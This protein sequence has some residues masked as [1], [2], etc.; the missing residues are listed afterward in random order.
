MARNL[1]GSVLV[2]YPSGTSPE[3]VC[4]LACC[5]E[6]AVASRSCLGSQSWLLLRLVIR[7]RRVEKP[8]HRH[9]RDTTTCRLRKYFA[10]AFV[11]ECRYSVCHLVRLRWWDQ[12]LVCEA[13]S[14]AASS[15]LSASR[16]PLRLRSP[17]RPVRS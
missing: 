6:F 15:S 1:I 12:W 17:F 5:A 9:C 14:G 2:Q 8:P 16:L 11:W 3:Q 13:A 4:D 10:S 7:R